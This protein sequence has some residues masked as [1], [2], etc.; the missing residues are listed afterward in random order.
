MTFLGNFLFRGQTSLVFG[1]E[2]S[3]SLQI[4]ATNKG[5]NAF[6]AKMKVDFPDDLTAVGVEFINVCI[7]ILSLYCAYL[8]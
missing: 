8:S 5:E 2:K 1:L 4:D 3:F 7:L 6:L